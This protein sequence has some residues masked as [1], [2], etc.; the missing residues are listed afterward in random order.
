MCI[1]HVTVNQ[2]QIIYIWGTYVGCGFVD[3]V[4]VIRK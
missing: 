2:H 4:E 3:N 1:L